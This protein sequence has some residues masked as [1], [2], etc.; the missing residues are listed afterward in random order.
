MAKRAEIAKDILNVLAVVGVLAV[1]V[2]APGAVGVF[3]RGLG[4]TKYSRTQINRAIKSL[5]NSNMV[6]IGKDGDKTTIQLTKKGKQKH[7]KY[8]LDEMKIQPQKKWDGKWRIVIFDVPINQSRNRMEF[9]SKLKEIGFKLVQ[10]SVWVCPY[11][12]EDEIDF[13]KEI[14]EIRPYVRI[15]TAENIDIKNDLLKKFQLEE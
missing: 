9:T 5:E 8:K 2:V 14:Y 11:P 4:L 3:A 6:S 13:L 7:L 1:A 15:I 12:C 10:K